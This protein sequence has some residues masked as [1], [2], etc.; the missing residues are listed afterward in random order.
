MKI[1]KGMITLIVVAISLYGLMTK[2]FSYA[3]LSSLL[4]GALFAIMGI[5][6]YKMKG[7]NGW[8]LILIIGSLL[9]IVMAL[10]SVGVALTTNGMLASIDVILIITVKGLN[11][12]GY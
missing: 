11:Q 4:L 10:F 3:P 5:E 7:K 2:D 8:G 6:E 9:I 1:I 12:I